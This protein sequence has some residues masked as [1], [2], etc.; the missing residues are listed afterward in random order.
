MVIWSQFCMGQQAV[1]GR[2]KDASHFI[3]HDG[4][5]TD[6]PISYRNKVKKSMNISP[7]RTAIIV[8]SIAWS[9]IRFEILSGGQPFIF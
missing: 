8:I 2:R 6:L 1:V 4:C 5:Y 9:T 7:I 3:C